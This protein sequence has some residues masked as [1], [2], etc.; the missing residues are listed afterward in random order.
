[1]TS[2]ERNNNY[3]ESEPEPEQRRARAVRAIN[4]N[5]NNRHYIIQYISL[6]YSYIYSTPMLYIL[7]HLQVLLC[8]TVQYGC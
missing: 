7:L 6:L 4:N 8:R 2:K 5:N 3:R 1:M